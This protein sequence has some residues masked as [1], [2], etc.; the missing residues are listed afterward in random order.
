MEI[1]LYKLEENSLKLEVLFTSP[2]L[3]FPITYFKFFHLEKSNIG[4]W[5]HGA[6]YYKHL[7]LS[8]RLE[9]KQACVN[10]FLSIKDLR[11]FSGILHL[12]RALQKRYFSSLGQI[13]HI[14]LVCSAI[15]FCNARRAPCAQKFRNRFFRILFMMCDH[16]LKKLRGIL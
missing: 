5:N 7:W 11:L 3:F 4:C 10:S 12:K 13:F 6:F 9:S 16:H 15:F 2:C 8:R 14:S 1:I